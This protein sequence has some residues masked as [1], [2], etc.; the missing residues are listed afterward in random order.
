MPRRIITRGRRSSIVRTAILPS[1]GS[2]LHFGHF[3]SHLAKSCS[4]HVSSPCERNFDP[5][6]DH[7][8]GACST[9][10]VDTFRAKSRSNPIRTAD[11][12]RKNVREKCT[13][14]WNLPATWP[15]RAS[16]WKERRGLSAVRWWLK[17]VLGVFSHEK[18]IGEGG[19]GLSARVGGQNGKIPNL[20]TFSICFRTLRT[21]FWSP[22]ELPFHFVTTSMRR[23]C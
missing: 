14:E 8:L 20:A 1:R 12:A 16:F 15:T 13:F 17:V 6:S 19:L 2:K 4:F 5:T 9:W 22:I 18:T 23:Y 11:V 10:C 21:E 7:E 3:F